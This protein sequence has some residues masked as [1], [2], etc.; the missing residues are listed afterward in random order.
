MGAR[1]DYWNWPRT[2]WGLRRVFATVRDFAATESF[3][4]LAHIKTW[5]HPWIKSC[6]SLDR[7]S[8]CCCRIAL[9]L[10][11]STSSCCATVGRV[12][13]KNHILP[14]TAAP[15][16]REFLFPQKPHHWS[17]QRADVEWEHLRPLRLIAFPNSSPTSG[18]WWPSEDQ[19]QITRHLVAGFLPSCP[20]SGG[21]LKLVLNLYPEVPK[22]LLIESLLSP[23]SLASSLFLGR[24]FRP[25]VPQIYSWATAREASQA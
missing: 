9:H 5:N 11:A 3:I 21:Y 1:K 20:I 22:G 19:W 7:N 15:F 6:S 2:H 14:G 23:L 18:L 10:S 17:L 25:S 4:G 12:F 16:S 8:H 24:P 13:G